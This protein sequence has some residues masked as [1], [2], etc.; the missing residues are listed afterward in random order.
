[1]NVQTF[2]SG[3]RLLFI[4]VFVAWTVTFAG[5]ANAQDDERN[6]RKIQQG[7]VGGAVVTQAAQEQY[8]LLSL[9]TG[10]SGSLLRN[11]WIITA[12]HCVDDADPDRSGGFITV[13]Q[14]SVTITAKWKNE[15]VRK[16]SRIISF[17]P[18]D[19]AIIRVENPFSVGGSTRA[20]NREIFRGALVPLKITAFG[21]GIFQLAQG[22]GSSAMKAQRDDQYRVG[23]FTI[24]EEGDGEYSFPSIG[25]QSLAGGDSGGPSFA[26]VSSSEVLVGVHSTGAAECLSGKVCGVWPGPGPQPDDYSVWDWVSE[27]PRTTDA[28]VA[29]IWDEIDRYLGAFTPPTKP[30]PVWQ[31]WFRVTNGGGLKAP[32]TALA[33]RADHIDLFVVGNDG[34]IYS[35]FHEAAGGWRNWF[36]IG[37]L[38]VPTQS[39]VTALATRLDH[40]DLFVVGNDGG[41]YSTYF[42]TQGGWRNWFRIGYVGV[43]ARANVAAIQ[44]RPGHIDLFVVGSDAKVYSTYHEAQGDWQNWFPIDEMRSPLGSQITALLSRPGHIDLFVSG[45]EGGVYS[46]YHEAAGGWQ[47]WSRI[48]GVDVQPGSPI[49]AIALPTARVSLFVVDKNRKVLSTYRLGASNWEGW[50]PVSKQEAMPGTRVA[51]LDTRLGHTDLF[52]VGTDGGIYSTYIEG[53]DFQWQPWFRVTNMVSTPGAAV[54]ALLA[55]AGHVDLFVSGLDSGVYSTFHDGSIE[56]IGSTSSSAPTT[57]ATTTS[58]APAPISSGRRVTTR[59]T[60]S[61][62][63]PICEYAR[64]ARERNN[65]AAPGLEQTCLSVQKG[66]ALANQDPLAAELRNQQADDSARQ[67]FHIGMAVAELQTALGPGKEQ[68]CAALHTAAEQGGCRIAVLFSVDRNRNAQLAATGAA[69]AHADQAVADLRN[70]ETDVFYRLG[71]DIASGIFGNPALGAQ[72]NTATGPGSLGIR[73]ALN[74]AAQRG[75]N[76]SVRFHLSRDYRTT[77]SVATPS[78]SVPSRDGALEKAPQV[79]GE[80]GAAARRRRSSDSKVPANDSTG[81]EAGPARAALQ[82]ENTIKVSVR[83]KKE[84]GYLSDTNA[85]GNIGPT[86]CSAFSVSATAG[87]DADAQR[88]PVRIS[89]DSKMDEI[90]DYY[91]CNY[92]VSDVP[93]N[94]PIMVSVGLS[95]FDQSL[96]WRGGSQGLPPSG[97]QRT[98][99][100][101]SGR[102]GTPLT[103][104]TRQP[105][106]RTLF[107]MVYSAKPN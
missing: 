90:G 102:A 83:Y 63:Q 18:M 51:A 61:A 30:P 41:V 36:R 65:P 40:I 22:S 6:I 32:I 62:A 59:A 88:N 43:T 11:N 103:L 104:T 20:Y 72:G 21:R 70:G 47:Q 86:A 3:T 50:V 34:G 28:A 54:T 16:S 75:F 33:P 12:A 25:G 98:I 64:I 66:E 27:T 96:R 10:C 26:M 105:R 71:F 99:V 69:I 73:D 31:N 100:M 9:D 14:D 79:I 7:L 94:Q 42:E 49:T 91:F 37:G 15:Q 46:T 76:D 82:P 81:S 44:P 97:Q 13:P 39:P 29:P 78:E 38:V 2:G 60:R 5:I 85:F 67:G 24:D 58:P 55:R 95:S 4:T 84:F 101:V 53:N 23:N 93:L 57:A 19:I 107:E 1:M 68:T 8:G 74:A 106:A 45:T 87:E 80:L 92:L 35:T 17:R 48:G 89:S 56:R 77:S 52:A